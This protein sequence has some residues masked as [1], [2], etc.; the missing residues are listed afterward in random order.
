MCW[1]CGKEEETP[2]RQIPSPGSRVALLGLSGPGNVREL[3]SLSFPQQALT[4]S[5]IRVAEVELHQEVEIGRTGMR[6]AGAGSLHEGVP[7]I[8]G[9]LFGEA[10][11]HSI[12]GSYIGVS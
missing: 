11:I 6:S 12:W 1:W 7:K 3:Q 2:Q 10:I 4:C 5:R 8:E 9:Y